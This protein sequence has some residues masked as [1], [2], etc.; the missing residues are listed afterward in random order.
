[1]LPGPAGIRSRVILTSSILKRGGT[2]TWE[3]TNP[4]TRRHYILKDR[5]IQW[6][7]GPPEWSLPRYHRIR[8]E[9][10]QLK[11]TLEANEMITKCVQTLYQSEDIDTAI[12]QVLE[13][14]W[15]FSLPTGH[16]LS[17]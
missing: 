13:R 2:H 3:Y 7:G 8:K 10:L 5:L 4:L 11:L 17:T 1:M 16:I 12:S 15:T 6:E 14:L 9:K